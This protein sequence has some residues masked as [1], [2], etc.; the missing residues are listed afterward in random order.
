MPA[1]PTGLYTEVLHALTQRTWV[2][3]PNARLPVDVDSARQR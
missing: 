2:R 1:H 3:T